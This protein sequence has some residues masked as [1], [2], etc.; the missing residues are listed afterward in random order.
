MRLF[1]AEDRVSDPLLPPVRVNGFEIPVDQIT[2]EI[3]NHPAPNPL[4][5]R[6]AA[7]RALVV[8]ELLLQEARRRGCSGTPIE[9]DKGVRESE[10]DA[11]VRALLD[12]AISIPSPT[13]AECRRF[14]DANIVRFQSPAIWEPAHILLSAAAE[15]DEAQSRL[16]ETAQRLLEALRDDPSTFERLAREYSDCPSREQGGNL[17]QVSPGQTT[18]AFEAALHALEPGE[19]TREPVETSYGLH[20]VRLDRR[21][22]GTTLPFAIVHQKIADYLAD[23]VFHKAVHQFVAVL[24]GQADIEGIEIERATSPLVQ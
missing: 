1:D 21:T 17:G 7:V 9:L 19:I 11:R 24:A 23:A 10:Q 6:E 18:P 2:R 5:A 13:E 4:E 16:R 8:K 3:Q 12:K 22:D 20:I 14:Y 15:D